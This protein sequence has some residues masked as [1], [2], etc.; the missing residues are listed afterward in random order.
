MNL[1]VATAIM[2]GAIAGTLMVLSV[3]NRLRTVRQAM[4]AAGAPAIAGALLGA[5]SAIALSGGIELTSDALI[6]TVIAGG[7]AG[8]TPAMV[9]A[10]WLHFKVKEQLRM[11]GLVREYFADNGSFLRISHRRGVILLEDLQQAIDECTS[12]EE[13]SLL[14]FVIAHIAEIG[15]L[16]RVD[17]TE[18]E[19]AKKQ[20]LTIVHRTGVFNITRKELESY[21]NRLADFH[22]GKTLPDPVSA[23]PHEH[24][25]KTSRKRRSRGASK[26]SRR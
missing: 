6:L 14:R 11:A 23:P 20:G 25:K 3:V 8:A 13:R 10:L 7:T 12:D 16:I 2:I 4:L 15:S 1:S 18:D 5:G 26:N 9:R 17:R 24:G 21:P 22:K 19:A